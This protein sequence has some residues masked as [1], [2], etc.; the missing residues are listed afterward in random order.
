[1]RHGRQCIL[2]GLAFLA[3]GCMSGASTA[4]VQGES[5]SADLAA[6]GTARLSRMQQP[7][8]PPPLKFRPQDSLPGAAPPPP[9]KPASLSTSKAL[10][11]SIRA[12]V[13]GRPIYDEEVMQTIP[14]RAWADLQHLGEPQRSERLAEVYNQ[15]LERLIEQEVAYQDAVRKLEKNNPKALSKL[16]TIAEQEFDKQMRSIRQRKVASEAQLKEI[17]H[18]LR[19]QVERELISSEYMRS[20]IFP[21]IQSRISH[22]E[23]EDYY[24]T[25]QNEF[26][27]LDAVQW[28]DVFIAVGPKLPTVAHA[29]R[30][31]ED[32]IAQCRTNDDFTRLL[33]FDE[34]DS[35]FRGGEG[36]GRHK[37]EI[38]PPE[39]EEVLFRLREGEIGPV[40]EI[41]TGVH[42]VRV[43]KR[44]YAGVMPLDEKTQLLIRSK[45]RNQLADREYKR[46]IRELKSRATIEI[47]RE[48]A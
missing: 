47:E 1:M 40:I 31:A 9:I 37:G 48:G 29:K 8:A 44:E 30:F 32:L 2:L 26:Q 38:K 41:S 13:N 43:L 36:L 16:K 33:Q 22:E 35:K 18:T 12:W 45:L 7:E 11:V 19:R 42:I 23:V 4:L 34:G 39:C 28:Q 6:A 21:Y 20:R 24:N 27:R 46:I 10:R 25:H 14:Q 3:S 5:L 15:A 17:E